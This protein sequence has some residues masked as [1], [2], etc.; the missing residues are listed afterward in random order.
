MPG[1]EHVCTSQCYWH[2]EACPLEM[3][4]GVG[5]RTYGKHV[6]TESA[7]YQTYD[8]NYDYEGHRIKRHG[9]PRHRK[10]MPDDGRNFELDHN[11]TD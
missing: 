5:V 2:P 9:E 6:D 4:W 7:Y 11:F 8:S 1:L 3:D 10:A